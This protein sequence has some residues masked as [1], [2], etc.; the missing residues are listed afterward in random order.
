MCPMSK[1]TRIAPRGLPVGERRERL[2]KEALRDAVN[3]LIR[4]G[5]T[6][7]EIRDNRL[8]GT[9]HLL[10]EIDPAALGVQTEDVEHALS[11]PRIRMPDEATGTPYQRL[12]TLVSQDPQTD[13]ARAFMALLRALAQGRGVVAS[14][15]QCRT[16]VTSGQQGLIYAILEHFVPRGLDSTLADVLQSLEALYPDG[17]EAAATDPVLQQVLEAARTARDGH[18]GVLST[19]ERLA[20]ALVLNRGDWLHDAGHTM[21]TAIARLGPE[22][23]AAVPEAARALRG[24]ASD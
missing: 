24:G 15:Q 9:L 4:Q 18:V 1:R 5:Q 16:S 6:P 21:A 22:W 10:F 19:T 7:A 14:L 20:A 13:E 3:Q 17:G 2:L 11:M 23:M 12:F 8:D